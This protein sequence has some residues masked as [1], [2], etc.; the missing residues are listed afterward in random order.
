MHYVSSVYS[1]TIL[2]H[3]TG[4]LVVQGQEVTMYI[5]CNKWY[6]LYVLFD[7]QLNWLG[8]DWFTT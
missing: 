3:V 4:L 1:V 7:C 5:I 2:L 6:V 8:W